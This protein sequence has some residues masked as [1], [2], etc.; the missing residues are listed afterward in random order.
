MAWIRIQKTRAYYKRFQVQFRRRR[1]GLTDYQQ[2]RALTIQDK[3]KYAAPKYRLVVRRSNKFVT[4]QII[5]AHL[6][7]D[8]IHCAAY[9]HELPEYGLKAGLNNYAACYA[10]GLLCARR[11]LAKIQMADLYKGNTDVSKIV[12]VEDKDER[13]AFRCFLDIGLS[14]T[15]TGA[16]VFA[17]LKGAVDGGL[18]IPYSGKRLVTGFKNGQ[19]DAKLLADR[20]Y[21]QHVASY[22]TELKGENADTYKARFSQFIKNGI[23]AEN[24][25]QTIETTH[26]NIRKSPI[27][28]RKAKASYKYDTKHEVKHTLTQR[29]DAL[30]A[31]KLALLSKLTK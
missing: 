5:S 6:G 18:N 26:A 29:K 19:V 9:S 17:A 1:D 22:M 30:Q 14:R 25:K 16:N 20:I 7:G 28:S 13:S 2:R 8:K 11:M 21:G 12:P 3:D 27:S 31:K 4:C 10:T 15:T 24:Y 23:S